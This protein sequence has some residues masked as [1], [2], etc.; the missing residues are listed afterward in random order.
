MN[1]LIG[2]FNS[3]IYYF[4]TSPIMETIIWEKLCELSRLKKAKRDNCESA[5]EHDSNNNTFLVAAALTDF[6]RD[7]ICYDEL[8][9]EILTLSKKIPTEV[10][11]QM[12]INSYLIYNSV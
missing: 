9:E 6:E 11:H 5:R 10:F 12:S 2:P 7:G 3:L 8:Y 1:S 4:R